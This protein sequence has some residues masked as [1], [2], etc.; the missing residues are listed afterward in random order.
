MRSTLT[1]T[2][3]LFLVARHRSTR[4]HGNSR[5]TLQRYWWSQSTPHTCMLYR[6]QDTHG[7]SLCL[8]VLWVKH[9][10]ANYT[11]KQKTAAELHPN[12]VNLIYLCTHTH[13]TARSLFINSRSA[14][15]QLTER[16][17]SVPFIS[18]DPSVLTREIRKGMAVRRRAS[19]GYYY[20][21]RPYLINSRSTS[22]LNSRILYTHIHVHTIRWFRKHKPA[23]RV[24]FL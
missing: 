24:Y 22:Q 14:T 4:W 3:S 11:V 20:T 9:A 12:S 21:P 7:G 5:C 1:P 15:S 10:I 16:V 19:G 2:V 17:I 23:S 8:V 13:N 6:V 18:D